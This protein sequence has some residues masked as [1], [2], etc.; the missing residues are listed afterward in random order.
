LFVIKHPKSIA[1]F[2]IAILFPFLNLLG[3]YDHILAFSYFSGKP[4]YCKIHFSDANDINTLPEH[5]K[6]N[7][8]QGDDN[9]YIDLNEWSART[10]GVI[11]YPE[12]RVYY[13]IQKE[14]DNYLNE[15][16]TYLEFY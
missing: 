3:F 13:K 2:L 4:K 5:I 11:V 10:I 14:V 16:N 9:Y 7:V 8:R 15:P 12:E 1:L 6:L